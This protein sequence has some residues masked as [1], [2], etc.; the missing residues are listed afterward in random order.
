M[1]NFCSSPTEP[2]FLFLFFINYF[3]YISNVIP[4]SK[5]PP[6]GMGPPTHLKNINLKFL[7]SKENAG[8]K[9]GAENEGKA[10]QRLPHLGIH[11]IC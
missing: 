3:I 11:P 5:F 2:Q 6:R 8:K 1:Y 10:I 4:P 7:L 9:S